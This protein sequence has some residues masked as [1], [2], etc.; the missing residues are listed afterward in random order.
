[1]LRIFVCYNSRNGNRRILN[2]TDQIYQDCTQNSVHCPCGM[3]YFHRMCLEKRVKI[4]MSV[5]KN[6]FQILKAVR[7]RLTLHS[8]TFAGCFTSF[9]PKSVVT[10]VSAMSRYPITFLISATLWTWKVAIK[11]VETR[12]A[13]LTTQDRITVLTIFTS[14]TTVFAI[15][16]SFTQFA[17]RSTVAR[18]AVS[19]S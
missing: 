4:F 13:F 19:T 7:H 1:M 2:S 9:S 10:P 16:I 5:T 12:N 3:F 8:V 17:V 14:Q 11:S 15:S 18:Q 6:F